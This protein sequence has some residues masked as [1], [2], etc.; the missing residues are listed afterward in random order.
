MVLV[1][2]SMSE[3]A[4]LASDTRPGARGRSVDRGV[5]M[6]VRRQAAASLVL[7]GLRRWAP[8]RAPGLSTSVPVLRAAALLPGLSAD[9]S[10]EGERLCAPGRDRTSGLRLRKPT[11]CPPELQGQMMMVEPAGLEPATSALPGTRS[12]N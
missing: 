10:P 2:A 11:L 3:L 4:H 5:A 1:A 6:T 8:R 7:T 9:S 12:A